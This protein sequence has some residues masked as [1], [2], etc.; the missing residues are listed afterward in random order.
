MGKALP[1]IRPPGLAPRA[2]LDPLL[3]SLFLYF[4]T[5]ILEECEYGVVKRIRP[6]T[7][8]GTEP[9]IEQALHVA[10][11]K[12]TRQ[13]KKK[14]KGARKFPL[15]FLRP[16]KLV[17][18]GDNSGTTF[19]WA[20][21]CGVHI[22]R[23]LSGQ[24]RLAGWLLTVQG[25]PAYGRAARPH[26]RPRAILSVTRGLSKAPAAPELANSSLKVPNYQYHLKSHPST[27]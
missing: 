20:P 19:L 11:I 9:G 22:Q 1:L 17:S 13:K 24:A 2:L 15:G 10:G 14:S 6:I 7:V 5:L 18:M 23:S 21:V 12:F 3:T 4:P 8:T 27:P 16:S 26:A 25:L